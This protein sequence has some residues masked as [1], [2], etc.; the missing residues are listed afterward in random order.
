MQIST[1]RLVPS[2]IRSY[3]SPRS[4]SPLF[5]LLASKIENIVCSAEDLC[6]V[7][8]RH[9]TVHAVNSEERCSQLHRLRREMRGRRPRLDKSLRH[10]LT[11][12]TERLTKCA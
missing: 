9:A 7:T 10:R 8:D 12:A 2:R 1:Q 4:F 11:R 3:G 5:Y 6:G